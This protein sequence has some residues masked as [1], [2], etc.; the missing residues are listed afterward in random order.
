MWLF[1]DKNKKM[2]SLYNIADERISDQLDLVRFIRQQ[3]SGEVHR[4]I[5]FTSLERYLVR[6]QRRQFIL[7]EKYESTS[8]SQLL[9][10]SKQKESLKSSQHLKTLL[11][12]AFGQEKELLRSK[13]MSSRRHLT[14][15][16]PTISSHS[17]F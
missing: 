4:R 17:S 6:H 15:Q 2:K 5:A 13:T 16:N 9:E 14:N 8:S 7:K 11:D 3:L 1:G 12:G 10:S